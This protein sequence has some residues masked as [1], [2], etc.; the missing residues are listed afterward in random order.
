MRLSWGV[1]SLTFQ[2]L[3]YNGN[4]KGGKYLKHITR[5]S[6]I[7]YRIYTWFFLL[8]VFSHTFEAFG[9]WLLVSWD[10]LNSCFVSKLPI[11]FPI[12][13]AKSTTF[14]WAFALLYLKRG[15]SWHGVV[16]SCL[17]SEKDDTASLCTVV[18]VWKVWV[19]GL[20]WVC[21]FFFPCEKEY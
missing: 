12:G 1:L 15:R 18:R 14:W 5:P 3:P 2:F 9:F 7:L 11:L 13:A 20:G 16:W 8:R 10:V 21:F 19:S 4:L 17:K 6:F